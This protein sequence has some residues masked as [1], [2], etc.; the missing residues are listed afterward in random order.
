MEQRLGT[1]Q[2]SIWLNR[3]GGTSERE[4]FRSA[5]LSLTD[6]QLDELVN[7]LRGIEK[8]F[9]RP[10]D[11]EWA[12]ADGQLYILQAR[13]ITTYVPL[14][15]EMLTEPGAPRQLYVDAA[16]SKGLTT[17]RADLAAR[18]LLDGGDAPLRRVQE[19]PRY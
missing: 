14:P 17:Q 19:S 18:A 6:T 8:L 13:P 4:V 9:E 11:I 12:F 3:D 10:I 16:L 7:A 5:E 15:P 1:K 2:L